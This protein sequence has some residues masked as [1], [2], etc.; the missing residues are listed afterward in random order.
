MKIQGNTIRELS[1]SSSSAVS[2]IG[3]GGVSTIDD[4]GANSSKNAE[5]GDVLGILTKSAS[6]P[7]FKGL[8]ET[9]IRRTKK[10]SLQNEAV[11][12]LPNQRV[13]FC[14]RHRVDASK[15]IEVRYN[16]KRE[17]AHYSNVQRCGSVWVCP[18]CS[19]QIS[20]GRR[21]ELKQ[22]MEYWQ[23]QGTAK[24]AGGMV[25]LL[26]LTNP[27]HHGDNLIQLLEGQKKALK[28]FWSDRKPKEMFKS[29][30]KVGHITATEV[31]HGVNGWH[32]HYHILLFFK[33]P[34][35][36][37][38]LRNFLATCWQN[39]CGKSG[40][41]VPSLEHG[42][43]LRDG[44]YADK[45][46]SKWGLADEVTKGHTKKG[47]E[48]SA[49]PWDLLRQSEEGCERSGYLF[50][51]FAEAFKGKRQLSWSKGLK[52][53]LK[54]DEVTDD[55]LAQVTEKDSVEVYVLAMELWRL[56]LRYKSRAEYLKA[57]EHDI[58]FGSK[59]ADNLIMDLAERYTKDYVH[60][61][62]ANAD[63][64]EVRAKALEVTHV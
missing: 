23:G 52:E 36:T 5:N 10:Y 39:C 11:K 61:L 22:G 48:G 63:L 14:I 60:E 32:P 2:D 50:Q 44:K 62:M 41:K 40:L 17:Q 26:T 13:R 8:A 55:E 7:D 27:H 37:K 46:V 45:Y 3:G 43:D 42:C 28:Y 29:L 31:T 6:T 9:A 15:G 56:I 51:V 21:Q 30:G 20:E 4:D 1:I 18:I 35:N 25:Y 59:R 54:V 16:E 57:K 19:A 12:L 33:Q 47:K 24:E 34:I 53:L 38:S 58:K 49:T 64:H